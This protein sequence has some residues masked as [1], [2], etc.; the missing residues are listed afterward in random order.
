MRETALLLGLHCHQPVDNFHHVLDEAIQKSYHPFFEVA[1]RYEEFKFSVHYSGWLLEYIKDK[2]PQTFSLMQ[3]LSENGQIEFLTGGFYEPILASISSDDR[4]AQI[5]KLNRFIEENFGQSPKGLWLTERVW[6][7]VI[8]KDVVKCGVEYVVV[9]DYHFI[10]CGFDKEKLNGY[11]ITEDEGVV[12]KIFPINKE[13]RYSIPFSKPEVVCNYLESI[14]DTDLSAGVIF[15]DGEKFGIWPETYEWVYEKGWLEEF[16][17]LVLENETIKPMLYKEY[18]KK[19]KPISLSY[20]PITSYF[21]MGEWSLKGKDANVLEEM[22]SS[23]GKTFDEDYIEK[24]L[25]GSVW[26]NFLVKYYEANKIHKRYIELSKNRVDDKNYLE[27]LYKAQTNDALWHGVFGGTYLPN[28]R[29][30]AYRF[31]IDCENIRYFEMSATEVNDINCDGFDEIKCITKNL[32]T[33]F[34]SKCGGQLIEW[35]IRDRSF[36]LQNTMSRYYEAYHQKIIDYKDEDLHND[37]GETKSDEIATIHGNDGVDLSQYQEYLKHDWYTKNSFIDHVVDKKITLE[38]FSSSTFKEYGDFANQPFEIIQSENKIIHFKRDG[39]IFVK[40]KKHP[41]TLNKTFKIDSDEI[42]FE[43][44]L[45]CDID[46]E[47]WYMQEY[48]LHFANL[49]DITI[50][51]N[52]FNENLILKDR[53]S[54]E[55]YDKYTDKSIIFTLSEKTDIYLARLDTLSQSEAGF[56]L[57]NQGLTIGFVFD[58]KP[59]TNISGQIEVN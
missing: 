10:S 27:S 12:L 21:E 47:F 8:I 59:K 44:M 36:N 25:K 11:F 23:L 31:I 46:K 30:N 32:I 52:I 58:I 18:L 42:I 17:K 19:V 55:I 41:T 7:S 38:E 57:T 20:L 49:K 13:L 4:V 2:A 50:N 45:K 1:S 34:D 51:S 40:D 53:Q 37:S 9:D 56:D 35:D 48:N 54:L 3:K 24:F 6:D 5:Q 16:I 15:D 29:D 43:I 22:K 26:K 28:L 33:I 14:A 39:G